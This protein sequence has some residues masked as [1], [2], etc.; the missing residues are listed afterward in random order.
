MLLNQQ[1]S[2]AAFAQP[3]GPSRTVTLPCDAEEN[4]LSAMPC[5]SNTIEFDYEQARNDPDQSGRIMGLFLFHPAL[6]EQSE[7]LAQEKIL[8]ASARRERCTRRRR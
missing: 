5:I 1:F 2:I 4:R 7:L 3:Q 6:L 8:A